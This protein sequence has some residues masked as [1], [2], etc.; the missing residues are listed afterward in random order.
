MHR[1]RQLVLSLLLAT[2]I[3]EKPKPNVLT[4]DATA[5]AP[6][7]PLVVYVTARGFSIHG[8]SG[9]VGPGCEGVA[10]GVTIPARDGGAHDFDELRRCAIKLKATVPGLATQTKIEIGAD[11]ST[12]YATVIATMDAVRSSGP[13]GDDLFPDVSFNVGPPNPQPN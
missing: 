6:T 8:P 1:S 13:T 2:S 12:P 9:N 3:R 10:T 11:K 4:L 7:G 5:P